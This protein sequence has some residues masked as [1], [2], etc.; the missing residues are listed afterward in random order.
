MLD[1]LVMIALLRHVTQFLDF[2]FQRIAQLVESCFSKWGT[3]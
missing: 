3:R 2:R 1:R